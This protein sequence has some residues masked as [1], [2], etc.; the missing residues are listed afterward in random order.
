MTARFGVLECGKNYKG[1]LS[2]LCNLCCC[3]D[4][5]EH[6][7]NNCP[8]YDQSN[9]CDHPDRLSFDNIYSDNIDDIRITMKRIEAV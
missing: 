5:E 7:K 6:H 8:K 2:E 1:R 4:D 9:F 3:L